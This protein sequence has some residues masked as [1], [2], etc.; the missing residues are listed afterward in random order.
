MRQAIEEGFILDVLKGYIPYKTAFN[1]SK[2]IEDSKRVSGKTAKRALAQW[3]S[4]HPTNV[5]QK[6]Q[7][8]IE[9]FSKNVAHRLDGK[10]KAMVVTSSRAAAIRYKKGF[11]AYIAK[12]P[13]YSA[14]RSL[15]A[16]SGKMTGK[17]VIHG[18]DV[19]DAQEI[20]MVDEGEEFTEV[21]MNPDV[22]G[23]DLRIAF[24]RPEYRVMLVADKFQ[25]GFDQPKLVAMYVDKKIAND[26][27]VVQTFS[28]LNRMAPGKD[29]VFII[30]FVND[31]A[32]VRRAFAMYDDG[33]QID[34]VQDF[35]V[36]YEVKE[37][38]D[39]QNLYE[40]EDLADFKEA[41][42]KTIRDITQAQ[43][44]Q[45]KALYAATE[46]PT[47]VFNQR[48]KMLRDA[49][50]TWESAFE[51]ARSAGDQASMNSAD[52]HR[53]E[54]AG[55]LK[56]LMTFKSG[57]GRFVRTYAYI[58]QL[59]DFG[60]PE[61]ENFAAFAKLLQK[62]LNGEPPESVD[63][64]GLV[65]T[66]FDIKHKDAGQDDYEDQTVLKP[67]GP[68]GGGTKGED[69]HYLTEIIDRLNR[70]FGEA[71]PLRDQATFVNHIVAI[72]RENDVVMAQVENNT[73]E[74]ALQGNLPGAV[75][76][77]VVRALTSHQKLATLVLKSDRQSMGALTDMI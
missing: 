46:R 56:A 8:I 62:R 66:G 69:P 63:L 64:K 57:L 2:Q 15:V 28:R 16:F 14:I 12:H 7:F 42:F 65:L 44:P 67:I 71:T 34:D 50:E 52:H 25:T 9:H 13:E 59:V 21:S 1:L 10:A 22:A 39:A 77:G 26:V 6:V 37:A 36:V 19:G 41:R 49:I 4:L 20:F 17:Q 11:D 47:R 54:Y 55:Q 73:R 61:L 43:E 60:D 68:G 51:K 31:P 35:N 33:A 32:N 27:E 29:E 24:E 45:H 18:D 38:L 72:A 58:A 74:Q 76:Q 40:S 5:T 48:L 3:M 70:L 53:Q 30:D 23:Q 75:Q